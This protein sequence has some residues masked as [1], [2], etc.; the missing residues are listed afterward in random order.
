MMGKDIYEDFLRVVGFE[1]EE[2]PG[3]LPEW[4]TASEK[5]GLTKEDV[6]FATKERIPQHFDLTLRGVRKA[7]GAEIREAVDLTKA[8]EYKKNGVKIVYGILPAILTN[9]YAIKVSGGDNVFVSFPDLFLVNVLNIF[10]HKLDPF[11]E[12]SETEGGIVYGCRHCALNKTRLAARIKG[13]IPSPDVIW[14]WGF[15]CDEGPKT[16]EYINCYYDPDWNVEITRLPHDTH[17]GEMDDENTE[18]VEYL[19]LQMKD[20]CK[21]VEDIIGIKITPESLSAAVKTWQR[22]AFKLGQLQRMVFTADPL[23]MDGNTVALVSS[24]LACPFNTGVGYMEEAVD[25][26]TKEGRESVN[27]GEGILPKGAPRVVCYFVPS[28]NPWLNTIYLENGVG[29]TL[30]LLTSVS[31]RQLKPPTYKDP[32]MATAEQWLRMPAGANM[33][34]EIEDAIE[35]I[36]TLKPD[37]VVWGFFDFD[38]WLGAHQKMMAKLI[39][40]RTGVPQYYLECD[41]WEDRDYSPEALRTRIESMCQVIKMKK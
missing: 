9:Y 10:F 2:I 15:N 11:L 40:E 35:K 23:A 7:L 31:K 13:V 39:E 38:R 24:V 1:E 17:F 37:A 26:L 6:R 34:M 4:R 16:D 18:R 21:K 41:F 8:N 28:Y 3:Y 25:I 12:T 33:G 29:L 20:S 32:Y 30:S 19:A 14:T 22:F 36:E 5:L 27:K